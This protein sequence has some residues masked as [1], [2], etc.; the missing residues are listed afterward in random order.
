MRHEGVVSRG[1]HAG[2]DLRAHGYLMQAL[3]PGPRAP[4]REIAMVARMNSTLPAEKAGSRGAM[5]V[6]ALSHAVVHVW[7]TTEEKKADI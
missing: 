6:Q 2:R 3:P 7:S 5:L 4:A 1:P